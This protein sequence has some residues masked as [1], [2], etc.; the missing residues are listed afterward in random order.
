[1]SIGVMRRR[2]FARPDTGTRGE[3]YNNGSRYDASP[4]PY[5]RRGWQQSSDSQLARSDLT[6]NRCCINM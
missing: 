1:M 4:N 5:Q 2:C 3:M 6:M